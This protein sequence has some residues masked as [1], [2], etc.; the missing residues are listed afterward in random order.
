MTETIQV[1][2]ENGVLRPLQPL[3]LQEHQE[4]QLI[5]ITDDLAALVASQR[6]ALADLAGLGSSG[7]SDISVAHDSYLYRK[8]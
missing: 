2:Y 7:H 6:H 3:S 4:V 1:I 8:D 5:V